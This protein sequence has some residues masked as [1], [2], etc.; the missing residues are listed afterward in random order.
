MHI[1]YENPPTRPGALV[2]HLGGVFNVDAAGQLWESASQLVDK[3]TRFVVFDFTRVTVLTSAGIGILIRLFTRLKGYEGGLAVFGCS[4]KIREI[5][6]IVMV[7]E[8]LKVRDTENQAWDAIKEISLKLGEAETKE[9]PG[10]IG[11]C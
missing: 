9:V 10:S 8:I 5:F 11:S 6:N 1:T 7:D 4:S 3:E 2:A